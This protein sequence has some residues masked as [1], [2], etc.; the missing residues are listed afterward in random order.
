MTASFQQQRRQFLVQLVRFLI[1]IGLMAFSWVIVSSL[2]F[3]Q[4]NEDEQKK[5]NFEIDVYRLKQGELSKV[6]L[7]YREVW[8]YHRSPRDIEQ[9]KKQNRSLRSQRD[10]FFVFFPYE[11]KRQCMVS[12]DESNRSFYDTCNARYFDL[13]GRLVGLQ[14]SD[15]VELAIPEYQFVSEQLIQIDAR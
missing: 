11:P 2:G 6:M 5:S 1:L 15:P 4:Q 7:R 12:W 10:A 8:V 3:N 13:A 14:G 9:L